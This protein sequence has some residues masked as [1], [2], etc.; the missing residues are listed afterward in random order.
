MRAQ[1]LKV[2]TQKISRTSEGVFSSLISL[3][4]IRWWQIGY[5]LMIIIIIFSHS[6][7]SNSYSFEHHFKPG[8]KRSPKIHSSTENCKYYNFG[9]V[10]SGIN[11][12]CGSSALLANWPA[13]SPFFAHNTWLPYY[14][15]SIRIILW[16]TNFCSPIR[17]TKGVS[18]AKNASRATTYSRNIWSRCDFLFFLNYVKQLCTNPVRDTVQ[19]GINWQ[20]LK[21]VIWFSNFVRRYVVVFAN[22]PTFIAFLVWSYNV[23]ITI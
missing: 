5:N 1:N 12:Q 18:S 8:L 10:T 2:D 20:K 9:A 21:Y 16:S 3:H 14:R 15:I 13:S 6:E 17:T 4:K 22:I 23:H 7:T 11:P 19:I